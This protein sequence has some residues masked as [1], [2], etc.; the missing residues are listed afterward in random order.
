MF[1]RRVMRFCLHEN[2]TVSYSFTVS[3]TGWAWTRKTKESSYPLKCPF[4][5]TITIL[6]IIHRPALYL[7]HTVSKIGFRLCFQVESIQ[8]GPIDRN[9]IHFQTGSIEWGS[10]KDTDR[11][12]SPKRRVLNKC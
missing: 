5:V 7:K 4:T 9:N 8:L 12:Y 6:D 2:A 11:I 10:P 3:E 1:I